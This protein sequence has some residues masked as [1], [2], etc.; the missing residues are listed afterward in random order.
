MILI[1]SRL[2]FV[3]M[4]SF[5]NIPWGKSTYYTAVFIAF[6]ALFQYL[7]V[8]YIAFHNTLRSVEQFVDKP[9][10][11]QDSLHS[12]ASLEIL[13]PPLP[14]HSQN[15]KLAQNAPEIPTLT[16]IG[17]MKSGTSSIQ[18]YFAKKTYHVISP[19]YEINQWNRC[20][21]LLQNVENS[22]DNFNTRQKLGENSQTVKIGKNLHDLSTARV[23]SKR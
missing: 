8:R 15:T 20:E 11:S 9:T 5:L 17:P 1:C 12:T 3:D 22:W 6:I 14:A 10:S 13:Q 7:S 16:I 18:H 2:Q 4:A 23:F 19:L 21:K